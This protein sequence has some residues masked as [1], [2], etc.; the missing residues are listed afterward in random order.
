MKRRKTAAASFV[1]PQPILMLGTFKNSPFGLRANLSPRK[2]VMKKATIHKVFCLFHNFFR[3][4]IFCP[5]SQK[6]VFKGCLLGGK[7][8]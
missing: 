7:N 2:C 3:G 6:R 4:E 5:K 1:M 8:K